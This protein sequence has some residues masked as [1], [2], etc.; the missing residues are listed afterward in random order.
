MDVV[1]GRAVTCCRTWPR[2]RY[3]SAPRSCAP[4]LSSRY[5]QSPLLEWC[6]MAPHVTHNP[7][8]GERIRS[9]RLLRGWSIRFAASRAGVSHASW[10]RIERGRQGADNRSRLAGIAAALGCSA[11]D[12]AGIPN[13]VIDQAASIAQANVYAMRQAIPRC[14]S[15][16]SG[17]AGSFRHAAPPSRSAGPTNRANCPLRSRVIHG[18]R[19]RY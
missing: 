14:A 1:E 4:R 3:R 12:L 19:Q 13:P 10:S 11:T 9:R 16:R 6:V 7:A 8:V 5:R 2:K 17:S 15:A 18:G